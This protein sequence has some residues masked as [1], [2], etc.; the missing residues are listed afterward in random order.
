ML[1][2]DGQQFL[3][4]RPDRAPPRLASSTDD[5]A[6]H[7]GRHGLIHI[8]IP[9]DTARPTKLIPDTG[10][11]R[12]RRRDPAARAV[13]YCAPEVRE[14]LEAVAP[15]RR[16]RLRLKGRHIRTGLV[17]GHDWSVHSHF[18][19]RPAGSRRSARIEEAYGA[20]CPVRPRVC[21][22]LRCLTRWIPRAA[23]VSRVYYMWLGGS[24]RGAPPWL[25][26]AASSRMWSWSWS[27]HD[28]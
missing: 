25:M 21:P 11:D 9:E 14:A 20:S 15:P 3:Q 28:G 5:A 24:S 27:R 17:T 22:P 10:A 2:P 12:D 23:V 13:A 1:A 8:A 26:S 7:F 19:V 4:V 18:G 16:D 6:R